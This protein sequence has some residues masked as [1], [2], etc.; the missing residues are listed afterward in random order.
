MERKRISVCFHLLNI[1][2]LFVDRLSPL[3]HLSFQLTLHAPNHTPVS[4]RLLLDTHTSLFAPAGS[5]VLLAAVV[6]HPR[7]ITQVTAELFTL[8][9]INLK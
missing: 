6:L 2:T 5:A 3:Q 1:Q 9:T 4:C 7:E 8:H